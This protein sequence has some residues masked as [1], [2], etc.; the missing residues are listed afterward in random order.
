MVFFILTGVAHVWDANDDQAPEIWSSPPVLA[1]TSCR[2]ELA[3]KILCYVRCTHLDSILLWI[4]GAGLW[5]ARNGQHAVLNCLHD[6]WRL[7]PLAGFKGRA[8]KVEVQDS[9]GAFTWHPALANCNILE[10]AGK[11]RA[12]LSLPVTPILRL[13][14]ALC[15][16]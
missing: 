8:G 9:L 15:I 13:Q 1:W 10:A 16:Q 12:H 5:D 6:L 11:S 14:K 4:W 7:G 2:L 3:G